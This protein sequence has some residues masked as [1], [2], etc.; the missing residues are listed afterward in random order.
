M[1]NFVYSRMLV[2]TFREDQDQVEMAANGLE[3]LKLLMS[4][5]PDLIVKE[6]K[7]PGMKLRGI[8]V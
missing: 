1:T 2:E 6:M 5:E 7:L 3:A 8:C 4:F